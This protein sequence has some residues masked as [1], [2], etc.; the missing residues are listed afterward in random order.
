MIDKVDGLQ[1]FFKR[2][3]LAHKILCTR[4]FKPQG[5]GIYYNCGYR[6][7]IEQDKLYAIGRSDGDIRKTVTNAKGGE[8]Y[9]QYGW[10]VDFCPVAGGKLLWDDA[11][12]FERF[13][14]FAE[15][16]GLEW[17]GRFKSRDMP[18]IQMTGGLSCP[19]MKTLSVNNIDGHI[20]ARYKSSGM[21]SVLELVEQGGGNN[22]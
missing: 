15:S 6:S 13:G 20:E 22:V 16:L 3:I 10:A 19:A 7:V 11:T 21:M 9:H 1:P 2:L 12:T 18:H 14:M 5:I 4:E 8:S 17:G